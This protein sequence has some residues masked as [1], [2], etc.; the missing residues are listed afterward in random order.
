[1]SDEFIVIFVP[2]CT[3]IE[4]IIDEVEIRSMMRDLC[5]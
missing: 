3:T 2:G 4:K 5:S 1:M